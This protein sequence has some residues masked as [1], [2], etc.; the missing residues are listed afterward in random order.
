MNYIV[1]SQTIILVFLLILF[2]R[3]ERRLVKQAHIIETLNKNNKSLKNQLLKV[4]KFKPVNKRHSYR[5]EL[6]GID[7][8]FTLIDIGNNSLGALKNRSFNGMIND[9]SV[10]G[11]KFHSPYEFPVKYNIII[12]INFTFQGEEFDLRGKIIRREDHI[13]GKSVSYGVEFVDLS[14]NDTKRLNVTLHNYQVTQRNK[15]S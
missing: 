12:K 15:I 7:S 13:K 6:P 11:L 4:N 3:D 10:G 14:V 2:I 5:I 8:K 1:L 9:I